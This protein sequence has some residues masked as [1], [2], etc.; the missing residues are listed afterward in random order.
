[1]TCC[2]TKVTYPFD[3]E[4]TNRILSHRRIIHL[5]QREIDSLF[6]GKS[7]IMLEAKQDDE[8]NFS[9]IHNFF[10]MAIEN[11]AVKNATSILVCIEINQEKTL[12]IEE[13]EG[14]NNF[15]C[16]MC[17]NI[18]WVVNKVTS[19]TGLSVMIISM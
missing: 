2:E 5:E 11:E 13:L 12:L 9:F 3:S 6:T 16:K 17:C 15:F 18:K 10:E 19:C 1:M 8:D 7:G 14:L 4:L